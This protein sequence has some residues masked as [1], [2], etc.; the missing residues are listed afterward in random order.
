MIP[1]RAANNMTASIPCGAAHRVYF[2]NPPLK[3]SCGESMRIRRRV[4]IEAITC[5]R[6]EFLWIRVNPHE[7]TPE[8]E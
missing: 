4:A 8:P 6:R 5:A 1:A 2:D 3:G 7:S